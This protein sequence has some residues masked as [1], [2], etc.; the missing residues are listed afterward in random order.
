MSASNK[1]KPPPPRNDTLVI[2]KTIVPIKVAYLQQTTLRFYP[3]NPRVYSIVHSEGDEDPSQDFIEKKLR[4]REHVRHLKHDIDQNGGL[5]DPVIVHGGTLEVVEGNSRL[6]A[7]RILAETDPLKWGLIKCYVLPANIS[8]SLISTLLGQYH[9]KGKTE[10]PP[11]EQAGFLHRR[12]YKQRVDL[13]TLTDEVGLKRALVKQYIETFQFMVLRKDNT[14]ARW[15]YY[16]EFLKSNKIKK[17]RERYAGFEDV[18]IAKIKS[19]EIDNAQDLRDKLP[20]ICES[21][22][23]VNR[24]VAG[25]TTFEDAFEEAENSGVTNNVVQKLN[26]FRMWVAT[27][28][29]QSRI[30]REQAAA[31]GKIK[32]EVQQIYSCIKK[33]RDELSRH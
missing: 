20:I 12:F 7:F 29:A 8:E 24:L 28:E 3:D 10:W 33:L 32:F 16:F 14:Q 2:R 27:D 9:L 26:R 15:S 30:T 4:E 1:L 25:K 17:A 5:T 22:R 19:G 21:T 11:Y 6:A 23:A 31:A 18:I 13:K